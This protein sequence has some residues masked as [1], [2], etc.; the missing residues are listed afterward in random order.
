MRSLADWID[1]LP[2][3]PAADT[4]GDLKVRV[5]L[6]A[7]HFDDAVF[8]PFEGRPGCK[9]DNGAKLRMTPTV[10]QAKAALNALLDLLQKD[11][12]NLALVN[13]RLKALA[14]LSASIGDAVDRERHRDDGRWNFGCPAP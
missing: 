3:D 14:K 4:L 11:Q 13:V 6:A 9:G 5:G 12:P 8:G 7:K 1:T 2:A 10:T